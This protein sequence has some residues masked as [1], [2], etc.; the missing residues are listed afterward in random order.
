[1]SKSSI[2]IP[3]T[4]RIVR[5]PLLIAAVAAILYIANA[6]E[7][8]ALGQTFTSVEATRAQGYADWM[9]IILLVLMVIAFAQSILAV[10]NSANANLEKDSKPDGATKKVLKGELVLAAI[11]YISAAVATIYGALTMTHWPI[12]P[13]PMND[14]LLGTCVALYGLFAVL[15]AACYWRRKDIATLL[16]ELVKEDKK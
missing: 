13:T 4:W 15:L 11:F 2:T 6:V 9:T 3:K 12:L 5:I 10:Y 8:V 16:R 14:Q 7:P 1:M